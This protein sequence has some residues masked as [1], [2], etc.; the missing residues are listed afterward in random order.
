M[1]YFKNNIGGRVF[2]I[3]NSFDPPKSFKIENCIITGAGPLPDIND[4]EG[5]GL[6]VS[7]SLPEPG[8]IKG[9]ITNLQPMSF[10]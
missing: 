8:L 1:L 6:G 9:K 5:S 2:S 4:G 10:S 7:G 3:G